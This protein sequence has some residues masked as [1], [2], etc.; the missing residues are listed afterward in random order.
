VREGTPTRP[1]Q[2]ASTKYRDRSNGRQP[3]N[4]R[5][6]EVRPQ[7]RTARVHM[8]PSELD[9]VLIA[10]GLVRVQRRRLEELR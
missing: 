4:D 9:T 3:V 8:P 10:G 5:Q 6:T 7:S 2:A 1:E